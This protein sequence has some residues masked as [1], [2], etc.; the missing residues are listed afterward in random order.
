MISLATASAATV[1]EIPSQ[2]LRSKTAGFCQVLGIVAGIILDVLIPYMTNANK[3][4]WSY[5]TGW[6]FAGTGAVATAGI[7]YLI[8]ETKG[9]VHRKYTLKITIPLI[10]LTV[11]LL[12]NWTNSSRG[13]FLHGGSPRP[14]PQLNDLSRL[15]R[16]QKPRPWLIQLDDWKR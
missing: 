4:N 16:S 15:R 6:F 12:P 9:Y 7:V 5:K 3:W 13:R 2:R 1:G 14:R 11:A 10:I 8:P